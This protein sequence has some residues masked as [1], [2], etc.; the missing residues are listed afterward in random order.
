MGEVFFGR[1][2]AGRPVAVKLIYLFSLMTS[3]SGGGF[4]W[5]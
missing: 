5:R 4:V 3:S 2:R 1:S